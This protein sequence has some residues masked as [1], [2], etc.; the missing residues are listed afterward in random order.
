MTGDALNHEAAIDAI[1]KGMRDDAPIAEIEATWRHVDRLEAC[2]DLYWQ[3]DKLVKSTMNDLKRG[4]GTFTAHKREGA[5]SPYGGWRPTLSHLQ[6]L[7]KPKYGSD[8]M[9]ARR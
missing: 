3:N 6:S 2:V 8:G 9:P 5:P 7:M 4:L 1:R